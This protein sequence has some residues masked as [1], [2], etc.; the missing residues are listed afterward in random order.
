[1]IRPADPDS[2]P[3]RATLRERAVARLLGVPLF[4][5]LLWAGV[6]VSAG[7]L[8]FALLMA[9][10]DPAGLTPT[11][12]LLLFAGLT[13]GTALVQAIVLRIALSPLAGLETTAERVRRG[14]RD[15]RA[16]AS[17]VED[18]RLRRLRTSF[19]GMLDEIE[20]AR[21]DQ[22][23]I[24]RE[25]LVRE[26]V[27]RDRVARELYGE[28]AQALAGLL[29]RLRLLV[30]S[31]PE[32][33]GAAHDLEA[34]IRDALEEVRRLARRLRP[35]EL[36]ELGVRAALAA[37]VRSLT[38][39]HELAPMIEGDVPDDRLPPEAALTL[40]RICQAA[41]TRTVSRPTTD[42][43]PLRISFRTLDDRI[44][45]D[46]ACPPTPGGPDEEEFDG[47]AERVRWTG[48]HLSNHGN[49]ADGQRLR[50]T[51]PLD[52]TEAS[53]PVSTDP[54]LNGVDAP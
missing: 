19:N 33:S 21:L 30:R 4:W 37:H 28:P 7:T 34:G 5:K 39:P 17:R 29:V 35:P 31:N 54:H 52:A 13:L 46:L 9:Q 48:G 8:L 49:K 26:E 3:R 50:L 36:D 42:A 43:V 38:V 41:I 32:I 45:V 15:A 12:F 16:G 47:W 24:A 10:R 18:L 53:T 51:L 23:R 27:E 14:D 22:E 11:G 44:V 25:T 6:V 40:F 1:M 20:A 2:T